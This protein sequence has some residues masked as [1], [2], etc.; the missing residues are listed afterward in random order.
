MKARDGELALMIVDLDRFKEINDVH[1]HAAGDELLKATAARIT[2]L[3]SHTEFAAR[4]G[5]D[6]FVIVQTGR[7]Q[8]AS[9]A[10][11]ADKLLEVFSKPVLLAGQPFHVGLTIGVVRLSA[12]R[13]RHAQAPR[14][15]R[16]GA[17]SRQGARTRPRLL[18][19]ARHGR[20]GARAAHP[21]AAAD[22]G[23]SRT[24]SWRSSTRRRPRSRPAR[25][26]ASRRWRAG[27]IRRTATSRRRSS[28]RS[29]RRR[30]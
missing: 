15:R 21:G 18:L 23:A 10:R 22:A 28:S 13:R 12:R 2:A 5:G 30:T 25:S 29:P 7:D 16:P 19:H 1:G 14:Q 9:A 26:S 11:L 8:P 4:L 24:T 3:L 27:T 6:E 20:D 17:L